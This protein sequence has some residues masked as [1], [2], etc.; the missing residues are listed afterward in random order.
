MLVA[1]AVIPT[2]ISGDP[3]TVE[4]AIQ[5][6][7][8]QPQH[9]C[10]Y[11][12][13]AVGF[14]QYVFNMHFLVGSKR[15]REVVRSGIRAVAV[16][17]FFSVGNIVDG[18][19]LAVAE[20]HRALQDVVESLAVLVDQNV[21]NPYL[22]FAHWLSQFTLPW[23]LLFLGE[24]G[25]ALRILAA[26]ITLADKNG[27][28]YRGQTLQLYRGWIHL[29]AMDFPGVSY[30]QNDLFVWQARAFLEQV[31]GVDGL[32]RTPSFEHGL[33]NLRLLR[34]VTESALADGAE[35][36]VP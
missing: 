7:P 19:P 13:I 35:V 14:L 3:Q 9:L 4:L 24:W 33:H 21:D 29:H 23:S 6:R 2:I 36:L 28:R 10:R 16:F 17:P 18:D 31:A 30:G 26:E 32:P 27:D 15:V 12:T 5:R 11:R 1:P 8:A 20:N 25:E 34:A 22:S